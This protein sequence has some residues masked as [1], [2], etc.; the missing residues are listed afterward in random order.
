MEEALEE[1]ATPTIP[2]V[3]L[4]IKSLRVKF[5]FDIIYFLIVY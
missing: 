4:P 3:V 5:F 2:A 1:T